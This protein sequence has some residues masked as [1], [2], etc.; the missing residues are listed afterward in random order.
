[1]KRHSLAASGLAILS[2]LLY[3]LA[4]PNEFLAYGSPTV[5]L[6]A[7]APFFAALR[8][9]SSIGHSMMI[10]TLF[11]ITMSITQFFWLLYFQDFSIWTL[12]GVAFGHA[13]YFLL[14]TPIFHALSKQSK[15][16]LRPFLLA[17]AW[18]G[19]EYFRSVGFLGFPWNMAAHPF[20]GVLPLAQIA[21]LAGM[22]P[23]SFLAVLFSAL[24]A[25]IPFTRS[26]EKLQDFAKGLATATAVTLLFFV[27]GTVLLRQENQRIDVMER[28]N[29]LLVQTNADYWRPGEAIKAIQKGQNLTREGL[30][31]HPDVDLVV[32]SEN[33]LQYPYTEKSRIYHT[34]PEGDSFRH[35]LQ[36]ISVPLLTGSPYFLDKEGFNAMNGAM[37]IRPDGSVGG[38]YGKSQLVPF[39]E[40]VPFWDFAPFRTF[41]EETVGLVSAGWTPGNPAALIRLDENT[42][43][44]TPICFEDCFSYL[45]R[46]QARLGAGLFVNLT[47]DSWSKTV[48]GETQHFAAARFRSV[49][50]GRSLVRSTNAGV[51]ALILPTGKVTKHLPLYT[52]GSL[53]VS[54]P[55]APSGYQT[56]YMVL[57]DWFVQLLIV[58]LILYRVTTVR[59]R[60]AK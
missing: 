23:L 18:C 4:M 13:I 44:A 45:T 17:A 11:S 34:K 2:A 49:E 57:G 56:A 52:D 58:A 47:N 42:T 36:D 53:F 33:S 9:V 43:M 50:T 39:A 37:L 5:A 24:A 27:T 41:M 48:A 59:N 22:W 46:Y 26:R 55:I 25:E 1:M 12:T 6:F 30:K 51:T 14:F 28:R 3:A 16:V 7:L 15:D 60:G 32:W 21:S 40:R 54:V 19:Y 8:L 31:S 20:G 29:L 10:G 38:V 35:F